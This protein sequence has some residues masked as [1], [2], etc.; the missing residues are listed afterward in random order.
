LSVEIG[1]VA[2][3][4]AIERVKKACFGSDC[5]KRWQKVGVFVGF[6][7]GGIAVGV[8]SENAKNSHT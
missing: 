6:A 4:R 8:M 2:V 7:P 5:L 3:R 1:K